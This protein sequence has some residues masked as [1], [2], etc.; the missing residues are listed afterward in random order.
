MRAT[1]SF[2]IFEAKDLRSTQAVR[3]ACG[4]LARSAIRYFKANETNVWRETTFLQ[5]VACPM[6]NSE[7]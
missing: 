2:S 3:A 5:K 4:H 6:Q 1:N 7:S